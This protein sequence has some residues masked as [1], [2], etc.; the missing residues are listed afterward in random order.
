MTTTDEIRHHQ[1]RCQPY[2]LRLRMLARGDGEPTSTA[3]EVDRAT[4]AIVAEVWAAGRAALTDG[5][6][7]HPGAGTFLRV[8]LDRLARAAEPAIAAARDGDT[9]GLRRHLHCFE[10]VT[11]AIWTAYDAVRDPAS[12]AGTRTAAAPARHPLASGNRGTPGGC[13][14]A[15]FGAELVPGTVHA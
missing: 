13:I 9:A 7:G 5:I 2:L 15:E 12:L 3:T 14:G 4:N 11:S 6:S 1:A 10:T 8:R